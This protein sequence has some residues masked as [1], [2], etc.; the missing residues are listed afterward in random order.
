MRRACAGPLKKSGSPLLD[1]PEIQAMVQPFDAASLTW[2]WR[3]EDERVDRLH[4]QVMRM[5]GVGIN[6]SRSATFAAVRDCA[7]EAAGRV[8]PTTRPARNR[9]TVPYLNEPWYC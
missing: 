2:P 1:L 8:R 7:G 4:A 3:H 5:V 9:A 6:G